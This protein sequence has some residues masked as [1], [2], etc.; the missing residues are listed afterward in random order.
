MHILHGLGIGAGCIV[1]AYIFLRGFF[2]V[3]ANVSNVLLAWDAR[4]Q[5]RKRLPVAE[6]FQWEIEDISGMFKGS[7]PLISLK[8]NIANTL[9]REYPRLAGNT[10]IIIRGDMEGAGCLSCRG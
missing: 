4:R 6:A 3:A 5:E 8:T 7:K 9:R 10:A 1:V 2:A